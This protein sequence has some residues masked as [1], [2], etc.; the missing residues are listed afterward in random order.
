MSGIIFFDTETTGLDPFK[1]KITLIQIKQGN[2]IRLVKTFTEAQIS[3]MR[4]VLENSLIVG[5]NLKFDLKFLKQQFN[6]NPENLFDTYIAEI[7]ISGGQKARQKGTATLEAVTK[8]YT[9]IQLNKS[10]DVRS[11]FNGSELT[12]E[13]IKY[14]AM[15]VAV[16]PEIHKKQQEQLKTLGLEKVFEIEMGCIPATVWLE[17][18][19]LP[20]D[21]DGLN[22][23][24]GETK[25]KI[26]DAELKVKTIL[27]E[28]GYKNLDLFGLPAVNLGS[29]IQ[30]LGVMRGI[31]LKIDSTGDE[32][33]S[34]IDH[35][36]GKA[37][38][39][40]R[41]QQKLLTGFILKYPEHVHKVTG[42]IQ[43]TF[44]QV[45]TNTGRFT[46]SKPNMQQVPHD[47]SIRALFKA[48]KGKK[49]ITAD[50]SQIELRIIAEVSQEPK[51]L[52]IYNNNSDLHRL[53]ASL[54]LNKP[55]SEITKEERQQAKAVNFGFA[56]G[57]GAQS[58]K[59]KTKNDYDIDISIEQAQE[60]RNT[61]FK[62]YP[63]LASYLQTAARTAA[64]QQQIRNKS[65]R[66]VRFEQGLEAWQ[67]E[68]MGRN[69]PIQSLSAD[70]TK[71]AMGRLY[72]KLKPFNAKLINAVHD[73]LVF[74]VQEDR[75]TEAAQI[76]KDEMEAAGCEYLKSI[77]CIV[78]VVME[79]SWQK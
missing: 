55:E 24:K 47:K 62:N 21:K 8:Q 38:K 77:P 35:P 15:D 61:F 13:Q 54:L 64:G 79:E 51:F 75:V 17:L 69:T 71:T 48:G 73:E 45:G 6:I 19:G 56:Y 14:A 3:E 53:T 65:G 46:S 78:E 70:I 49:I 28:S 26:E 1:D 25:K 76:I 39:E 29:P 9:G 52:E 27:K 43:P 50:Y 23:V 18:S 59:E 22:R 16:L 42:R 57:L 10:R 44:N 68:N 32:V 72:H 37:I 66:I 74:E 67:Y 30:L 33:I 36:I 31:G 7:L 11:S 20:L 12:A 4:D 2:K 60:F 63:V 34:G 5:H 40:Y 58:F 41:K